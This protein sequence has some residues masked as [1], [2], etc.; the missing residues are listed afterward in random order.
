MTTTIA[1]E[2]AVA[3]TRTAPRCWSG[4]SYW[5]GGRSTSSTSA[6]GGAHHGVLEPGPDGVKVLV[7]YGVTVA[8]LGDR[9]GVGLR[10][11]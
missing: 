7:T 2:E 6:Y 3:A 8:E 10:A 5:P 11:E 1:T 9:L 4:A